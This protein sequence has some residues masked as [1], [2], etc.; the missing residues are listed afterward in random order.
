MKYKIFALIFVALLALAA[1][2]PQAF[3]Q[4]A[5]ACEQDYV[6]KEGDWL[7]KIAASVYGDAN[8][9]LAIVRATNTKSQTDASYATI[10]NPDA[11]EVGMKLCLPGKADALGNP[12]PTGLS[13]DAL[14]NATY[15]SFIVE[16]GNVT[17]TDGKNV[18][19]ADGTFYALRD[20]VALGQ[21]NDSNAAAVVT[22]QNGGG[23][24]IFYGLHIMQEE[25]GKPRQVAATLLGDRTPIL[26]L[27]IVDN[28]VVVDFVTQGPDEPMCCAT[29]RTLAKFALE[30]TDL[31][32]V[33]VTPIGTVKDN[34]TE[35][36]TS[37]SPSTAAPGAESSAPTDATASGLKVSDISFDLQGLANEI[38]GQV[39]QAVPYSNNEPPAPIGAPEHIEFQF[40]GEPRMWV[41]PAQEYADLWSAAGDKTVANDLAALKKI[42][43]EKPAGITLQPPLPFL[44]SVGATNDLV[45]RAHYLDFNGGSGIAYIGRWAQGETAVL[46]GQIQYA[47]VGLTQ[48]GKYIVALRFPVETSVLPKD[49]DQLSAEHIQ[50]IEANYGAY[51]AQTTALLNSLGAHDFGPDLR[52]LDGLVESLSVP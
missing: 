41:V 28:Q 19:E 10:M 46:S 6:V 20:M 29:Q 43:Q 5:V 30:G 31:K 23:S 49:S 7:S 47:F 33:S 27:A 37:P 44:P 48:D 14:K 38:Q 2:T 24:G 22:V 45:A 17:L 40:D 9:Y 18:N 15:S 34:T 32:N 50:E 39:V 12:A 3:A 11:L 25:D 26:D 16:N 8:A 51:M 21:L 35:L 52:R 4:T 36:G 1:L 13:L 42:L